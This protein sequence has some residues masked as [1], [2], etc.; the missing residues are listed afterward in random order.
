MSLAARRPRVTPTR[1][2]SAQRAT[3][4]AVLLAVTLTATLGAATLFPC[5]PCAGLRTSDPSA[6]AAA[7]QAGWQ[8]AGEPRVFAAWSLPL[9]GTADAQ[10]AAALR[11]ARLTPWLSLSFTV[12]PPLATHL[13]AVSRE[14]AAAAAIARAAGPDAVYQVSWQPGGEMAP[15]EYAFLFKRA[16]VAITGAAAGAHVATA[17][18][19][20]SAA[21]LRGFYGEEVAAYA[22]VV[23]LA[24]GTPEASAAALAALAELDPGKPVVREGELYPVATPSLVLAGAALDAAAGFAATLYDLPSAAAVDLRPL[25][26]LAAE[27]QGD[28]SYDVGSKP[29][30]AEGWA[31]VRGKDLA[32]R[33][34]VLAPTPGQSEV[35]TFP[36]PTLTRIVRVD[37][38][39]GRE[40]G[41]GGRRVGNAIETTLPKP[42]AVEVLKIERG[43]PGDLEQVKERVEVTGEKSIPVEEILRRL[44][45]FEDAQNRRLHQY[46]AT[47]TTSLRFRVSAGVQTIEA[48][49]Q[50]PYFVRQGEPPDWMWRDFFF[51]GV[52]W[53]GKTIPEIPLIQP[54]KAAAM[55]LEIHFTKE[56]RYTL[57][58]SEEIAGRPC[59]VV[60]FTPLQEAAKGQHLYRGTVWIDQK[61]FARVR[62]RALQLGLEG[63]VISNEETLDY[64][65]VDGQG[66]PAAWSADSYVLPLRVYG[67]QILSIL[68][69]TTLVEKETK[70]TDLRLNPASFEADRQQ[71]FD[72]AATM[73]RDT[74]E[75]LRYLAKDKATGQRVVREGF[76]KSKLFLVGG[77]Y[78][79]RSLDYP[80]PLAGVNYFSLD[81]KGT[82]K[83]FNVFFAGALATVSIAQP[84]VGGS[85]FDV[86]G[87]AF[88]IA[89]PIEDKLYVNGREQTGQTLKSLPARASL[90]IGHPIGNFLKATFSYDA[91]YNHFQRT[92]DTAAS[93]TLPADHF[94]HSL[95]L[96]LKLAREG[97]QATAGAGYSMRS[98][99]RAWG[100]PGNPD[101]A[102]ANRNFWRWDA[103]FSKTWSFAAFRRF[104]IEADYLGGR[105]LDRF[106]KYEFGFFGGSRVHGYASN[107]LRADQVWA[108]HATYGF[109]IGDVFRID[110]AA[111]V[112][113]ATDRLTGLDH[114]L[115][116]GVG[117]VGTL[118]GPWETVVNL[119][120]G[121]PVAGPEHGAV[122]Y[123]VFL[124]LFK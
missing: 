67:Q 16:S 55:P 29:A 66:Q 102:P 83:Q 72:S 37:P 43:A 86:G 110:A 35:L 101:Y 87:N 118:V 8:P 77:A 51:N 81:I 57:R 24:G 99:W 85:G 1:V 56:Y 13:D 58:G 21:F 32:L 49:F 18:L 112:A 39:S 62:T 30:G 38:A 73:V 31:F 92:R 26:V 74:P 17:A 93:F 68:N 105:N 48:T 116:A 50:G 15:A 103:T 19:P 42:L 11:Q 61:L 69:G 22:D 76:A 124:K 63:E 12:P 104:G 53:R 119:D 10:P 82:G 106:S 90:S 108:T 70:L 28:V 2:P 14:L 71:A 113:W 34:V 94:V 91:A 5:R 6:L 111:D 121:T 20:A 84:R 59:W 27:F 97:Y 52:R 122:V 44:Q 109:G 100:Y 114:E 115:L 46:E 79:E 89:V 33:V 107:R 4:L 60:D 54:Q 25:K 7:W 95:S 123:V 120:V 75:G 9:D 36:D 64:T 96:D 88:A 65:P 23:A 45:A 78:Y 47:N 41:L 3:I 40:V 80:L 117:L 98:Q